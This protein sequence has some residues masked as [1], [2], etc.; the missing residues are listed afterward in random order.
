[1]KKAHPWRNLIL[2]LLVTCGLLHCINC[3]CVKTDTSRYLMLH[4]LRNSR[5]IDVLFVGSSPVYYGLDPEIIRNETGLRAFDAAV[6]N[7][8]LEGDLALTEC[9]FETNRPRDV[10]LSLE[11][12]VLLS[13]QESEEAEVRIMPMLSPKTAVHYLLEL[14]NADSRFLTRL[15]YFRSMPAD[16]LRDI[17]KTVSI[18]FNAEPYIQEMN[19]QL[20]DTPYRGSGY[21]EMLLEPPEGGLFATRFVRPSDDVLVE[22]PELTKERILRMQSLCAKNGAKLIVSILPLPATVLVSSPKVMQ[23]C[24]ELE[25]F[26]AEQEISFINASRPSADWMPGLDAYFVDIYH[27]NADGAAIYSRAMARLIQHLNAGEDIS[28]FQC[29]SW[30]EYLT[31][32]PRIFSVY[33]TAEKTAEEVMVSAGCIAGTGVAPYY[34]IDGLA[35]DGSTRVI[36]PWQKNDRCSFTL[37]QVNGPLYVR[38]ALDEHGS[39]EMYYRL[40]IR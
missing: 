37:D 23:T 8:G 10:F 14:M 4:E 6:G 11:P 3:F 21:H 12:D 31:E 29:H 13:V 35:E 34:R 1:M 7:V 33:A 9:A 17:A 26:C 2:F 30:S 15:F 38:A 19:Q 40:T 16:S 24:D 22:F 5:D 18:R 28:A 27:L 32:N 20:T 36:Q 39:G 25:A